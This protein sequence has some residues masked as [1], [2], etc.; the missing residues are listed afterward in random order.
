MDWLCN[1]V[2]G[3]GFD[4][5]NTFCAAEK[6]VALKIGATLSVAGFHRIEPAGQPNRASSLQSSIHLRE[7]QMFAPHGNPDVEKSLDSVDMLLWH[8]GR[9]SFVWSSGCNR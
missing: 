6:E 8:L 5:I 9:Q 1:V 4:S 2:T 7:K 3:R